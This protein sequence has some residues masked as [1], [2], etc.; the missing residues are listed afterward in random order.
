MKL[1]TPNQ[2]RDTKNEHLAREVLRAKETSEQILKINKKMAEAEADFASVLARHR[3]T[4]AEEEREHDERMR[5]MQ[6]EVSVLEDRKKQALI[7]LEIY[8]VQADTLLKEAQEALQ[9]TKEKELK[10]EEIAELLQDRLDE[11]GEKES[12]VQS[13]ESRLLSK[14]KGIED[15]A[16]QVKAASQ[17]LVYDQ[18]SF[19]EIRDK[20]QKEILERRKEIQIAEITANAKIEKIKR[21]IEAMRIYDI[22]LKDERATLDRIKQRGI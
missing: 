13:L 8:K 4:W 17:Q 1:L 21:D 20:Q 19:Y 22:Q 2:V 5:Q 12:D 15:Q 18:Q 3:I 9:R 7:P 10:N 14:Q 16:E 6:K 11:V